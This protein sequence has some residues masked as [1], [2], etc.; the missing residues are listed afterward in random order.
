MRIT[1]GEGR[2]HVWLEQ[3]KIGSDVLF[4]LGG[5]EKTHIGGILISE[6]D[7]PIKTIRLGNHYDYIALKPIIEKARD[8]YQTT[9]VATGGIHIDN[10]TKD[11]IKIIIENCIHLSEKIKK[12]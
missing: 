6:P 8:I 7:Q 1:T 4:I 10:A 11:E 12:I 5:G 9:L 2:Y 3:Y